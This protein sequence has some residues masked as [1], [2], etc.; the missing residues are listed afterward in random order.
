MET[1]KEMNIRLINPQPEIRALRL[2]QMIGQQGRNYALVRLVLVDADNKVCIYYGDIIFSNK[3][4]STKPEQLYDKK[5]VHIWSIP[6][7]KEGAYEFLRAMLDD[8]ENLFTPNISPFPGPMFHQLP[9]YGKV[10]TYEAS[11]TE[12]YSQTAD[13]YNIP[14]PCKTYPMWLEGVP[15]NEELPYHRSM[16]ELIGEILGVKGL[17]ESSLIRYK[18]NVHFE[19]GLGKLNDFRFDGSSVK[20]DVIMPGD[21]SKYVIVVILDD[22]G[23]NSKTMTFSDGRERLDEHFSPDIHR[24]EV[25]LVYSDNVADKVYAYQEVKTPGKIEITYSKEINNFKERVKSIKSDIKVPKDMEFCSLVDSR[26]LDAENKLGQDPKD[27]LQSLSDAMEYLCGDFFKVI[28]EPRDRSIGM[29]L[30]RKITDFWKN[31]TGKDLT[32]LEYQ[33]GVRHIIRLG[34]S[35]EHNGYEPYENEVK[36]LILLAWRGYWEILR[37]LKEVQSSA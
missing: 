36:Y 31:K 27:V 14:F 34:A 22:K 6:T 29:G 37:M 28:E 15:F 12:T 16:G 18:F 17:D 2:R 30:H 4:L 10:Q 7:N 1:K 24:A 5:G 26:L 25:R 9:V 20:A 32:E 23:G 35:K 3:P 8:P 21:R 13:K 19:I 33:T 11:F